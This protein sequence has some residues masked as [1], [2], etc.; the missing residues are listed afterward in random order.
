MALWRF[1]GS[2]ED[3]MDFTGKVGLVAGGGSGIGRTTSELFAERGGAVLVADINE[4]GAKATV[5]TILRKG[6]RA[7]ACRVDV[8]KEAD[9]QSAVEQAR[10]SLGRLDVLINCAGILRGNLIEETT[11]AEWRQVLEINLTGAFFQ[12]KAALKA[13]R[14]QGQGGAIVL[15]ASR[16]AIRAREGMV[17]YGASKAGILQLTQ[18]AA[19]E[20]APHKIR[21]N[22]V[23]PGVVDS[24][25]TRDPIQGDV[26]AQLAGWPKACPLGR[27]GLPE[28]VAKA[29]LFLASDDAAFITGVALPVDG[30]RTIL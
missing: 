23:V 29:M 7:E 2:A 24:P 17:A 5:E 1:N 19:V 28:D 25:M 12:T 8:T 10:R 30:G 4:A 6:G 13:M 21:A 3:S 18:T 14:E 26:E 9:A 11:E 20:G 16:M 15:I 22:C 27:A